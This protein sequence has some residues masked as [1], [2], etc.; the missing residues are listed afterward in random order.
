MPTLDCLQRD[1]KTDTKQWAP[2]SGP[3]L[4]QVVELGIARRPTGHQGV[5][6]LMFHPPRRGPPRKIA[7]ARRKPKV[8]KPEG[9]GSTNVRST[10][11]GNRSSCQPDI[12]VPKTRPTARPTS[13]KY[14]RFKQNNTSKRLPAS[15]VALL[16]AQH[17]HNAAIVPI[18]K[19]AGAVAVLQLSVE[20]IT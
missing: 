8:G 13:T 6:M 5:V 7:S 3:L 1:T 11:T 17:L 12:G 16:F 19:Q 18:V 4:A 20:R 14:S 9:T 2:A 10:Y 15:S